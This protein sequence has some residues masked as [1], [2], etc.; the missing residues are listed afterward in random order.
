MNSSPKNSL[1]IG[2]DSSSA[3]ESSRDVGGGSSPGSSS[4][5]IPGFE[6]AGG[7]APSSIPLRPAASMAA[8]TRYGFDIAVGAR[9]STCLL[10]E[11]PPLIRSRA[12]RSSNPQEMLVGLKVCFRRRRRQLTVGAISASMA[13]A[14][15]RSPAMN[16]RPRS[17]RPWESSGSPNTLVSP[18]ISTSDMWVWH[19]LP[20]CPAN[21]FDMKVATYPSCLAISLTPFLNV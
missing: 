14:Y 10:S 17:L 15:L 21:G 9:F 12:V 2:S 3:R 16:R 20:D 7:D 4:A 19:P 11:L 1:H 5:G 13:L 8:P 18:S 6:G